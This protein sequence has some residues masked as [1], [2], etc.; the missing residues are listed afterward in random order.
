MVEEEK[1][2]KEKK[3]KEKEAAEQVEKDKKLI[4]DKNDGRIKSRGEDKAKS[5]KKEIKKEE[6]IEEKKPEKKDS[7]KQEAP[8][9]DEAVVYGR[10][11]RIS[12]KHAVAIC[13]MLRGENID[14]AVSVLGGVL[15][16]KRAVPMKGEIP[17]RKGKIMSG[18]FP[19]NATREILKLLGQLNANAQ[20]NGLE[21]EKYVIFCKADKAAR[22]YRRFGR[23]R[24]KRTNLF[25]KLIKPK[26]KAEK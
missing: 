22:P 17:H 15:Q 11:L 4:N 2:A 9:K 12:T 6:K 18:R 25:L 21:I 1:P 3:N 19:Q 7:K 5:E 8:K 14:R 23:G 24:F 26:T 16:K 13:N 20:V 10:N